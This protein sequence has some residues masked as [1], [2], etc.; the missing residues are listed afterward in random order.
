MP[1]LGPMRTAMIEQAWEEQKAIKD[2]MVFLQ[3]VGV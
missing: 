2:V 1:G 3:G